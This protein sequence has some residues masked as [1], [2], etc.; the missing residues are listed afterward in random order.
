MTP[1]AIVECRC[2]DTAERVVCQAARSAGWEVRRVVLA[3]V[4][5]PR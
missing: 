5:I 1:V 2:A 3:T 4:Y